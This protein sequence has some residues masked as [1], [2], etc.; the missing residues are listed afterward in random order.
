MGSSLS[1]SG[2]SDLYA[3]DGGYERKSSTPSGLPYPGP[4]K[5][6]PNQKLPRM[7]EDPRAKPE[8]EPTL[9]PH[10]TLTYKPEGP[11]DVAEWVTNLTGTSDPD[12]LNPEVRRDVFKCVEMADVPGLSMKVPHLLIQKRGTS[13]TCD[14]GC[15]VLASVKDL[16]VAA[17]KV[18]LADEATPVKKPTLVID[19]R[20]QNDSVECVDVSVLQCA[21]E[22][23]GCMF[24]AASNFNGVECISEGSTPDTPG[25]TSAYLY[26]HTQGP[27]A[28]ISA[29]GA[30]VARVHAAF[31]DE[32]KDPSTWGQTAGHQIEML[33]DVSRYFTVRNGYVCNTEETE[34]L[35]A[36]PAAQKEI[37][38][39]VKVLVH[40]NIDAMYGR[41]DY[42]TIDYCHPQ[43]ICQ[44][45]CAAMNLAQGYSGQRNQHL[46]G[47]SEKARLLLRAAYRG[48]LYGA[49][50]YGCKKVYL[51]LIGGGVFGNNQSDIIHAICQAQSELCEFNKCIEEIHVVFFRAPYLDPIK[52]ILQQYPGIPWMTHA[53][54]RGKAYIT[55]KHDA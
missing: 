45:F 16:E 41:Y 13:R 33:G 3:S 54:S 22:N 35:P 4:A 43:K 1:S 19:F 20:M 8:F 5:R 37:E 25:F 29:G 18:A 21:T 11:I 23:E 34:P 36:D 40:A 7:T 42:N 51:T 39:K 47:A 48:T 15:M 44:V 2:S 9:A 31:Y 49:E 28:S 27:A 52:A 6:E 32:T 30:A 26:D 46:P 55:E 12:L 38:D 17:R 24:Q 50:M 14:A 53:F 10:Y